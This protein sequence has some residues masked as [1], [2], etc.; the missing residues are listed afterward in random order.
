[1]GALIVL[2]PTSPGRGP[3]TRTSSVL[4]DIYNFYS[5]SH[6]E[7]VFRSSLIPLFFMLFGWIVPSDLREFF[8]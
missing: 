4:R 8:S 7:E 5:S 1:V 6:I 2:I 3:T